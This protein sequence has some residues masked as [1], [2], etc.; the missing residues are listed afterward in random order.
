MGNEIRK[1]NNYEM[2]ELTHLRKMREAVANPKKVVAIYAGRFHPYH[3]GHQSVFEFLQNEYANTFVATSRKVDTNSPFTFE[4]KKLMMEHAGVPQQSIACCRQ[5][6]MP[7]EILQHFNA[8]VDSVVF[9][10]SAK[11]MQQ[12]PRFSFKPKKNGQPSYFQLWRGDNVMERFANHA[13]VRVAPTKVFEVA[14]QEMTSASELRRAFRGSNVAQQKKIIEDMYGSYN[15]DI[16]KI[17]AR[18]L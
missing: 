10:V 1:I 6:Y 9:A 11:D 16:H 8:A 2:D 18:A 12:D 7:I 14:G 5:P 4:Q 15:L 13:Y 3:L 17:M